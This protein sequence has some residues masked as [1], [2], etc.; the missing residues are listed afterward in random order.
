MRISAPHLV[1]L[2]PGKNIL[3]I[4]IILGKD[5]NSSPADWLF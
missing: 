1:N 4:S 2:Q 3:E 5:K